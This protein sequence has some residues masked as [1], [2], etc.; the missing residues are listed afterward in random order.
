[1][2]AFSYNESVVIH[3]IS[4]T[5]IS[6][7]PVINIDLLSML[8]LSELKAYFMQLHFCARADPH[9]RKNNQTKINFD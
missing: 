7:F 6:D 1:M 8:R 4:H 2:H 5:V 3:F 9:N